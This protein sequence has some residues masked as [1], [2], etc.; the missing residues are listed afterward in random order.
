MSLDEFS[1]RIHCFEKLFGHAF[2]TGPSFHD[3]IH[4]QIFN[5]VY[6]G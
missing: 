3:T 4:L 2:E 1:F 6:L 5:Q